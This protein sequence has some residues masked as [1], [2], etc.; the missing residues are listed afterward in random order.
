MS[1]SSIVTAVVVAALLIGTGIVLEATAP[2]VV[3]ACSDRACQAK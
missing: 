1:K 2:T 3:S